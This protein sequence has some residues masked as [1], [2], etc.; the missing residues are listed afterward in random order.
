VAARGRRFVY[1][2]LG[3]LGVVALGVAGISL[4]VLI[5][6][7]PERVE[8]RVLRPELP[9]EVGAATS[10]AGHVILE[11]RAA[12]VRLEPAG[13]GEPLRVEARYDANAFALDEQLVPGTEPG[14]AW[15]YRLVFGEDDRSGV[16]AG[17][18]SVM[19]GSTARIDVFLPP[20][21]PIDLTLDM[22]EGGAVVRLGGLWLKTARIDLVSG[23]LDLDV[24][25][26]LREP[27]E[28]LSIHSAMG[29]ALVNNVGNAS[30]KRLDVSYRAGGID[31]SLWGRWVRDAEIHIVGGMGGGVV[32]LPR[33]VIIEG[34][35]R[36]PVESPTDAE[37]DTPT[38][39]FSV[40]TGVGG[41]EFAG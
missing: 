16:F 30:P 5:T 40:S 10:R 11:I 28:S 4:A 3:C 9:L 37:L 1:G 18:V 29:G 22:K 13:P 14:G 36:G 20:D 17:L 15:S 21:V 7:K 41:L 31:M 27:M 12:E 39:R 8:D 25:E 19:R 23:A 35:D 6:I 26:V 24:N 2:C 38:L 34:L 32:H 33:G